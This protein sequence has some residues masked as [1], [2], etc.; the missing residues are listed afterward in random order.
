MYFDNGC[1]QKGNILNDLKRDLESKPVSAS[2]ACRID[3]GGTLDIKTFYYPLHH[4]SPCTFNIALDLKTRVTLLPH[5]SG[6][7][8]IS[9]RGFESD[10]YPAD[11]APFDAP[12]GLMLAVAAYFGVGG[13]YVDIV[14]QSPPRSALGGSSTA[15]VALIGALSVALKG[16]VNQERAVLLAHAI[17]ESVAGVPCGIQDQLA[18]A[19]GGVHAWYWPSDPTDLPFKGRQV[20]SKTDY[21]ILEDRILVAYCGVPHESRDINSKWVQAFVAGKKRPWWTEIVTATRAFVKAL[22]VRDWASAVQAM[23]KEVDIRRQ[24]TPDVF[25][26][27][28]EA[29]LEK[30][31]DHDCAARFTGAGGGGCLWALGTAGNIK[32]LRPAWEDILSQRE[33]AALINAKVD[34][35]GL[36]V[37]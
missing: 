3:C 18:A 27:L 20:L 33:A 19:Y 16:R 17:E 8:K 34:P 30:A 10:E 6:I 25:D 32:K 35:K 29:L 24:M 22:S 28:G 4:L 23:N 7:V 37:G 36:E 14:S 11:E 26:D 12:L 2:A 13:V 15:A 5:R 31:R 1:Y 21:P 9:S